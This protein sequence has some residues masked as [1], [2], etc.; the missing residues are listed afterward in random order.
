MK[1]CCNSFIAHE[2]S[3]AQLGVSSAILAGSRCVAVFTWLVGG[4]P[5]RV[6]GLQSP[7]F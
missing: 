3:F 1:D 5:R 2:L 4:A 6:A 7:Q